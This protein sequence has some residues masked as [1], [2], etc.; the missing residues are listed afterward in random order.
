MKKLIDFIFGKKIVLTKD[1]KK[2]VKEA[3]DF[4]L[5]NYKKTFRDLA[6]YDRGDKG[7]HISR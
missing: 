6:R 2:A 5:K 4:T 3:V 7:N 1:K